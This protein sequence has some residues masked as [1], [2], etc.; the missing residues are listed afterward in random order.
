MVLATGV[1]A[2]GLG[3]AEATRAGGTSHELRPL[4]TLTA[5]GRRADQ[6]AHRRRQRRQ[7]GRRLDR[8]PH[9]PFPRARRAQARRRRLSVSID[10]TPSPANVQ[11]LAL[12]VRPDGFAWLRYASRVVRRLGSNHAGQEPARDPRWISESADG[13]G[14]DRSEDTSCRLRFPMRAIRAARVEPLQPQAEAACDEESNRRKEREDL[15]EAVRSDD[16]NVSRDRGERQ[17]NRG[18]D[19]QGEDAG[20]SRTMPSQVADP[21]VPNGAANTVED[22]THSTGP[23]SRSARPSTHG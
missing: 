10:I 22:G 2:V 3:P 18:K 5:F 7:P 13:R 1:T 20:P 21:S 19:R 14:V 15:G 8:R 9:Q 12:G 23:A 17:G 4:G 6:A 11:S 16:G